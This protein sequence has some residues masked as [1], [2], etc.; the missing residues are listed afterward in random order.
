M[1][2]FGKK[3][4]RLQKARYDALHGIECS[5]LHG[6]EERK[7]YDRTMQQIEDDKVRAMINEKANSLFKQW[8]LSENT[9]ASYVAFT[10]P[11][12]CYI[13]HDEDSAFFRDKKISGLIWEEYDRLKAAQQK[14]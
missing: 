4:K 9:K 13:I 10:T 6:T 3:R 2:I 11:A 8:L 7:E 12:H 14:P 5:Y 1:D